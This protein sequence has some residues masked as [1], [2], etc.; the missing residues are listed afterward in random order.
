MTHAKDQDG[1]IQQIVL[2]LME[3]TSVLAK[4]E[5]AAR[6]IE[7]VLG[8]SVVPE[9]NEIEGRLHVVTHE[10]LTNLHFH[11]RDIKIL[12]ARASIREKYPIFNTVQFNRIVSEGWSTNMVRELHGLHPEVPLAELSA[13]VKQLGA[14]WSTLPKVPYIFT[15]E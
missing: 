2:L 7:D 4:A 1:A 10:T 13:M 3:A 11:I 9:M 15:K 5:N 14:E 12:A 8:A 6:L